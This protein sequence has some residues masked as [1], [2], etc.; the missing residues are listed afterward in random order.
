MLHRIQVGDYMLPPHI[1]YRFQAFSDI[2]I[3]L[4]L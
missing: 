2:L 4:G 3:L 1:T